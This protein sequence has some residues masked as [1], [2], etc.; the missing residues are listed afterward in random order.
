MPQTLAGSVG[1]GVRHAGER[2]E[3]ARIVPQA[4]RERAAEIGRA[5]ARFADEEP[6]AAAVAALVGGF[7]VGGGLGAVVRTRLAAAVAFGAARNV[8]ALVGLDV[9]RRR[10]LARAGRAGSVGWGGPLAPPP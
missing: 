8:A 4:A 9:L 1:E 10:M 7:L 2:L 5:L 6:A 3:T